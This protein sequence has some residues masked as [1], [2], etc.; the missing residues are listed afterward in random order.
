MNNRVL[1]CCI[2]TA[3]VFALAAPVFAADAKP[4]PSSQLIVVTTVKVK[5]GM[6]KEWEAIQSDISNAY[7]K[8]G[9]PFRNVW[10]TTMF[11]DMYSYATASPISKFADLDGDGPLLKAVGKE[12]SAKIIARLAAVT[13]SAHRMI[14]RSRP[15]ISIGEMKTLPTTPVE[16]VRI[17]VAPGRTAD[18]ENLLKTEFLPAAKKGGTEVAIVYQTVL[19]GV[20]PEYHAV[21]VLNK[22]A[23]FD[24][25]S[26]IVKALGKEGAAKLGAKFAGISVSSETSIMRGRPDLSY[27]LKTDKAAAAGE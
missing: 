3:V 16:L 11:G 4:Q 19:G 8:S 10:Q 21:I 7:Q 9:I 26:P 22:L 20:G 2:P 5:P 17:H 25:P 24:E 15:D 18:Y 23:D 14:I 13:D 6:A 1:R 27:T 12:E